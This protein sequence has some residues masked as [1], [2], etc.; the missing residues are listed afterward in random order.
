MVSL[1]RSVSVCLPNRLACDFTSMRLT[2][3]PGRASPALVAFASEMLA[4]ARASFELSA[5]ST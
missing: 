2:G 1:H 3:G 5:V 4:T